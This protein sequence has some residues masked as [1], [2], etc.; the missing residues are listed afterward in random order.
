[1]SFSTGECAPTTNGRTSDDSSDESPTPASLGVPSGHPRWINPCGI[2]ESMTAMDTVDFTTQPYVP[3]LPAVLDTIIQQTN[4]ALD[5]ALDFRVEFVTHNFDHSDFDSHARNF[6]HR[7]EWLPLP[8]NKKLGEQTSEQHLQ[9][10]TLQTALPEAYEML[11]YYA[12]ALEQVVHNL[13]GDPLES[14]FRAIENHLRSVLAE[15]QSAMTECGIK[16]RPDVQRTVMTD[17][18][19]IIEHTTYRRLRDWYI[20][21]DYMIL[22]EYIKEQFTYL[23]E[24]L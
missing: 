10:S 22:L 12:V 15:V 3:D 7:L 4:L 11:Q 16:Q 6:Q 17:E 8:A 23:K 13:K 18:H 9:D 21:R 2:D 1:M 19:R 24:H 14:R 20:Y 5:N